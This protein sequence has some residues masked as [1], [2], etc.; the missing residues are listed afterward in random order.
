MAFAHPDAERLCADEAASKS[1]LK[2]ATDA[3]VKARAA[4][5]RHICKHEILFARVG[6]A[7]EIAKVS[8][9]PSIASSF[10]RRFNVWMASEDPHGRL[11]ADGDNDAHL[12]TD[13]LRFTPDD[14]AVLRKRGELEIAL[15]NAERAEFSAARRV[16]SVQRSMDE[17]H[18]LSGRGTPK[19][20]VGRVT[21]PVRNA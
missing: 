10:E 4:L 16:K 9:V 19:S 15:G 18:R 13:D 14:R 6:Q 2:Q 20:T 5:T 21:F 3:K 11:P 7:F 12:F 8:N 1:E 17:H